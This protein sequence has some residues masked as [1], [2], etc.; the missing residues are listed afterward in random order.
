[1]L[2][3]HLTEAIGQLGE[4]LR[5]AALAG[6]RRSPPGRSRL[7]SG[8]RLSGHLLKRL[9]YGSVH[10][11]PQRRDVRLDKNAISMAALEHQCALVLSAPSKAAASRQVHPLID[12]QV[13]RHR[14]SAAEEQVAVCDQL[15]TGAR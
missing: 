3:D 14:L 12:S 13:G 7:R 10:L 4:F 15:L 1:M 9:F 5:R 2:P 6:M 11:G 8:G